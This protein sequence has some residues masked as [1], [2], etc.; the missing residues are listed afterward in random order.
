MVKQSSPPSP[1]L[2]DCILA[3]LS[4]GTICTIAQGLFRLYEF[5]GAQEKDARGWVSLTLIA[6]AA[7]LTTFGIY[8][9]LAK[10]A[11]AGMI[12]PITGFSNSMVSSGIEYKSEGF[13]MGVGARLFTVAGPVLVFGITASVLYG[14]VLFLFQLV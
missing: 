14:L 1:V 9:K 2:K 6:V 11:G 5:L 13:V 8:D 4:G 10:H 7:I 12:V 3:F